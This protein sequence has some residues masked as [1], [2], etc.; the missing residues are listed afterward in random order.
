MSITPE[1][2]AD[3]VSKA[4]IK[5]WRL[6]QIYWQHVDSEYYSMNKKADDIQADFGKLINE[7][8]NEILTTNIT[9]P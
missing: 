1:D 6:G 8:R 7:V 9:R 4:L 2:Q 5:A 3:M